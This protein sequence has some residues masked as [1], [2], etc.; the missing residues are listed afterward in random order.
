M[1]DQ[2]IDYARQEIINRPD[3]IKA[4]NVGK[5]ISNFVRNHDFS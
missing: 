2:I 5:M 1:R 3:T 4:R